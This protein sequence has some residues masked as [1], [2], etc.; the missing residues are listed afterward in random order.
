LWSVDI[1]GWAPDGPTL[2][3]VPSTAIAIA[4][5]PGQPLVIGTSNNQIEEDLNGRWQFVANGSSPQYPG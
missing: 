4:A 3:N 2:E 1:D 5:A